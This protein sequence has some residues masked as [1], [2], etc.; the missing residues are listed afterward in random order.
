MVRLD[1]YIN[2]L[3]VRLQDNLGERVNTNKALPH[4]SDG[5]DNAVLAYDDEVITLKFRRSLAAFY[6]TPA[7]HVVNVSNPAKSSHLPVYIYIY[8]Q[9]NKHTYIHTYMLGTRCLWVGDIDSPKH[10]F[11]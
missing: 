3:T 6:C 11:S 1:N 8:R 2:R 5:D 10:G 7:E 9:T 4:E